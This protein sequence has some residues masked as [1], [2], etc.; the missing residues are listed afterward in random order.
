M[1]YEGQSLVS[2]MAWAKCK[3]LDVSGAAWGSAFVDAIVWQ[4]AVSS[5]Q[6]SI[7][8]GMKVRGYLI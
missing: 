7:K 3:D 6:V 8:C 4:G 2:A 5:C 1:A